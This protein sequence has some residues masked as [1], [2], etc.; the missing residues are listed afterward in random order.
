MREEIARKA[1]QWN[2]LA[3]AF[4][5]EAGAVSFYAVDAVSHRFWHD[6]FPEQFDDGDVPAPEPAYAGL[7][8]EVVVG[9]DAA[10]GEIV[11]RLAP[12]D[13][14]IVVSDHGFRAADGFRRIWDGHVEPALARAGLVPARDAFTVEG[15]FGYVFVRVHPGPFAEREATT[16]RL[17]AF[18]GGAR[19]ASGEA[20][21]HVEILDQAER[22]ADARRS[23]T[24]RARQWVL[25]QILR[26]VFSV[27]L[28][29]R[30]H[31]YL[32]MRPRDAALETA[33]PD[34]E[35]TVG[36]LRMP[37]RDFVCG[38]GF[39]G[40]HD[41]T[42]VLVAAGGGLRAVPGRVRASVLDVAPLLAY[43]AGAA[44][45]DDL[46]HPLP[47]SWIEPEA[48]AARP[49]RRIA[50]DDLERL[51]APDAAPGDDA[52]VIERLRSMGYVE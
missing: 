15:E 25:R 50:A 14:V 27:H 43:L 11:S 10:V 49:P 16:E 36:G 42:A 19:N 1:T 3:S 45:P 39:T 31:A 12:D 6:A 48:L 29:P 28:D 21:F 32:L 9:V 4:E 20:L 5:I 8:E 34:G 13:A 2:A 41:E 26:R 47:E 33:W 23:W 51:P 38:D 22:P 46:A 17:A 52:D 35:I 30:A 24:N 40:A 37:L 44:L 7:L 18:F